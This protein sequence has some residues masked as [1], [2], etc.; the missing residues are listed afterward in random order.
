MV[1]KT[2]TNTDKTKTLP[3]PE[4][5]AKKN[6]L[7]SA[8]KVLKWDL[9]TAACILA[10]IYRQGEKN[11]TQF[12]KNRG[13]LDAYAAAELH[14]KFQQVSKQSDLV[15]PALSKTL[16][17]MISEGLFLNY[18]MILN[19]QTVLFQQLFSETF[20]SSILLL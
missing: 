11:P 1:H 13:G 14:A 8:H 10:L 9:H 3:F 20:H 16:D 17:E 7:F 12:R 5:R 19:R 4:K 2:E 15:R 6:E 18:P